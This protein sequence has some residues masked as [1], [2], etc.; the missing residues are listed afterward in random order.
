MLKCW[1]KFLIENA[2]KN[3]WQAQTVV[4]LHKSMNIFGFSTMF[5]DRKVRLWCVHCCTTM[6][7]S[8]YRSFSAM[9]FRSSTST[10]HCHFVG[11][12]NREPSNEHYHRIVCIAY[13]RI[14]TASKLF[15][16]CPWAAAF[17]HFNCKHFE[18]N[19]WTNDQAFKT[20]MKWNE[21]RRK[22]KCIAWQASLCEIRSV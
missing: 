12:P 4:Y 2:S 17:K 11:C 22:E 18:C 13:C 1:S 7:I 8:I 10:N 6:S 19:E 3:K 16:E 14:F 21:N 20:W 5:V 15:E 9:L